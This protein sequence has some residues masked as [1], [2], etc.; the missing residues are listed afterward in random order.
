M[1]RPMRVIAGLAR[2]T[3][4]RV[5]PGATARPYLEKARGA[6]FNSL[7]VRIPESRIL[8]IFAGSGALGIEALSRGAAHVSFIEA[9]A[10]QVE[11]LRDNLI[12]ARL[13]E[14]AEVLC[15]RAEQ[16]L[17]GLSPAYDLIL[18]DPPFPD[19][20]AWQGDGAG[21]VIAAEVVRLLAPD[22]IVILR[23]EESAGAAPV[24]T[25]LACTKERIYGRSRLCFYERA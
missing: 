3:P 15:G 24:L 20:V 9:D 1:A 6:L 5:A 21:G 14:N 10:R 13:D 25:D 7:L 11:A 23:L 8:D 18:L 16:S 19:G 4:L 22:G 12:R 17:L 2:G